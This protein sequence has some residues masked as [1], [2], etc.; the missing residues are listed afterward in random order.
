M[1]VS[2]GG[3]ESSFSAV[4]EDLSS[5]SQSQDDHSDIAASLFA[6]TPN[7]SNYMMKFLSDA[8]GEQMPILGEYFGVALAF[9]ALGA[10]IRETKATP[11]AKLSPK[12][13][14]LGLQVMLKSAMDRLQAL[15]VNAQ[16][17]E[18]KVKDGREA[19]RRDV[20]AWEAERRTLIQKLLVAEAQIAS[21]ERSRQ[22]DAKTNERVAGMFASHEQTWKVERKKLKR[23]VELL[24][25]E[26]VALRNRGL[27]Q[28]GDGEEECE[29]CKA[30]VQELEKL[31]GQLCEKEFLMG[32]AMQE[33]R[34]DQH[35]RNQ[36]AGKLAMV[37][38][39]VSDLKEKLSREMAK[40][41]ELQ[42]VIADVRRKH[43]ET[44][45]KLMC[46]MSELD[47]GRREME[48]VSAAKMNQNAIIEELLD[49]LK[50]L[51]KDV[52]EKEEVIAA[53]MKKSNTERKER[54]ELFNHLA[55]TK[56]KRK[57][58][59]TEKDR[60]KRLAEER[61][62][63]MVPA[64]QRGLRRSLGSKAELDK[65]SEIQR[66]HNEEVHG[67]RS[68]Y[69]SKLES[70]QG[71]LK[72]Y[73]EK[74]T[75]L[76]AK[77]LVHSAQSMK[78]K[79]KHDDRSAAGKK[80]REHVDCH[81]VVTL[82]ESLVPEVDVMQI[83]GFGSEIR[84]LP[85]TVG[86]LKD[87]LKQWLE[88]VKT[89]Q[90]QQL[91][92]GHCRELNAFERQ[93]RLK[94]ERL[95]CFRQQLMSMDTES[96][97][98]KSEL[99]VLKS[100]MKSETEE[101]TSKMAAAVEEK[102]RAERAV[103]GKDKELRAMMKS[104]LKNS[105]GSPAPDAVDLD[106][107]SHYDAQ[108]RVL[109]LLQKELNDAR[110]KLDDVEAAHQKILLKVAEETEAE[111]RQKDHQLAIAEAKLCQLRIQIDNEKRA[112]P[113]RTPELATPPELTVPDKVYKI[114]VVGSQEVD[115]K[116]AISTACNEV[117]KLADK[118]AEVRKQMMESDDNYDGGQL[119][120]LMDQAA[121][122]S[123]SGKKLSLLRNAISIEELND[124]RVT[125]FRDFQ[126]TTTVHL[127]AVASQNLP[128]GR[129]DFVSA[130]EQE[131]LDQ[132]R[133]HTEEASTSYGTNSG[134]PEVSEEGITTSNLD[135]EPEVSSKREQ[136]GDQAIFYL[137]STDSELEERERESDLR[138]RSSRKRERRKTLKEYFLD[139]PPEHAVENAF[140]V[141]PAIDLAATKEI[142]I[143]AS[144]GTGLPIVK[145]KKALAE[146]T[147]SQENVKLNVT[148][149]KSPPLFATPLFDRI[150]SRRREFNKTREDIQVLGL[151]LE[152]RKI[153][154]QLFQI[155]RKCASQL[156]VAVTP[157]PDSTI[158][159]I[160][161]G[162]L[163]KRYTALTGKVGQFAKQMV[164]YSILIK[165]C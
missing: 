10:L 72:N 155:D 30:K 134:P 61:A 118:I 46:A 135:A 94:D 50:L 67:L 151:A 75:K 112:T 74:V 158:A 54:E 5:T 152:V 87:W 62:R 157:K 115:I 159:K 91:E 131:T 140:Q 162:R 97:N 73:E 129:E 163:N 100:N 40:N 56:S 103:E 138:T 120:E 101:L 76:E 89:H 105:E 110:N 68:M 143:S 107:L 96:S 116:N 92:K 9:A 77:I 65:L 60:W 88:V 13:Q 66:I 12:L 83:D 79:P 126:T 99:E 6:L 123:N 156:D 23:E 4:M 19:T 136:D 26:I 14:R 121:A 8:N 145:K 132:P 18:Q 52:N 32:Q 15:A 35:E 55:Q 45:N 102:N 98:M 3:E 150:K 2:P 48:S 133:D 53:L 124:T 142:P 93:M 24:R 141:P 148:N 37:E 21:V 44:E 71:E 104:M 22:E 38:L 25:D 128:P 153:E 161:P 42:E 95:E 80:A 154:E 85:M 164:G 109:I 58:A 117:E 147:P 81:E 82:L 64:P 127:E 17:L 106:K 33:A 36:L 144:Q 125:L 114:A 108:Q 84:E 139:S 137:E 29:E 16:D 122:V 20:E 27:L 11:E 51:Q 146:I 160:T 63:N 41:A 78:R 86:A 165:F 49:N 1:S 70:L 149:S 43:E 111:I 119:E 130:M 90:A 57:A 39:C 28:I 31:E 113:N 34:A 59:E 7:P 47:T 69:T